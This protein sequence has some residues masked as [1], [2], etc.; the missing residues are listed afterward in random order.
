MKK[1]T[2]IGFIMLLSIS[3]VAQNQKIISKIDSL[4]TILKTLPE[5][6]DFITNKQIV[7]YRFNKSIKL[8]TRNPKRVIEAGKFNINLYQYSKK[9]I[10]V[11]DTLKIVKFIK[12]DSIVGWNNPL[13]IFK[14]R[15]GFLFVECGINNTKYQIEK[16]EVV[17]IK[18]G[19]KIINENR[20]II[21]NEIDSLKSFKQEI[22]QSNLNLELDELTILKIQFNNFMIS[23]NNN[24]INQLENS[25]KLI[26]DENSKCG[27]H[28]KNYTTQYYCGVIIGVLGSAISVAGLN[29]PNDNDIFIAG[30]ILASVGFIISFT[31]PIQINKAGKHLIILK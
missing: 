25:I 15:I 1:S 22:T 17:N 8:Q 12:S 31:A 16:I 10:N 14:T 19:L 7:Y 3:L 30:G 13:S 26:R 29:S 18:N 21:L 20:K 9:K 27:Y 5:S 4:E 24:K 2:L 6:Y 23:N 11:G 28:L